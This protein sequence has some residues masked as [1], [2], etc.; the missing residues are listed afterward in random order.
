MGREQIIEKLR[1]HL[2]KVDPTE[3][4]IVYVL[5]RVRK[6][7]ELEKQQKKYKYL[8]FYCNWAFHS[9][10]DRTA[11][12]EEALKD[13]LIGDDVHG[14]IEFKLFYSDFTAF[15][16]EKSLPKLWVESSSSIVAL[17]KG[18]ISIYSDTPLIF[19][20]TKPLKFIISAPSSP[21]PGLVLEYSFVEA[22]AE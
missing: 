18:L 5:S 3:C 6:I 8:N 10:I 12:V 11:V 21:T 15:L 2:S 13:L 14:V 20:P 22:D 16:S 1:E 17:T 9:R 4:Q 7:L 19:Y